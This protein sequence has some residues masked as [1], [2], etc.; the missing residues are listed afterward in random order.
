MSNIKTPHAAVVIWNYVNRLGAEDTDKS[1]LHDV[2]KVILST[3]SCISIKTAKSKGQPQGTFELRLAP[4]K[5]W[6]SVLSPGSWLA[7]LMSQQK[8]EYSDLVET[9]DPNKIKMLGRI[10]SV[11]A[12]VTVNQETGARSTE[13]I[14]QGSDWGGVFNTAIY[15]DPLI[16]DVGSNTFWG[17]WK[18]IYE[19]HAL[20]AWSTG[21]PSP[22][23][24][25]EVLLKLWGTDSNVVTNVNDAL[26]SLEGIGSTATFEGISP[27]TLKSTTVLRFPTEVSRY[28][29]FRQNSIADII[30]LNYEGIVLSN[31]QRYVDPD[32]GSTIYYDQ[33]KKIENEAVGIIQ[34]N[35]IFGTHTIWQLLI[36]NC[37]D[38][39]NELIADIRW[40]PKGKAELAL[41]RRVRPFVF[42]EDFI[43]KNDVID[44]T[45]RFSDVRTV[46]IPTDE[47][48]AVDIG[49]N[50][51]DKSNFTE[52]MPDQSLGDFIRPHAVKLQSQSFDEHAFSREGFRPIIKSTKYLAPTSE[53]GFDPYGTAKWKN[54]LREW[55][56]NTH[57]LLNGNIVF[58]GQNNYIQVGDNI[59]F[60]E[61]LITSSHNTNVDT[62]LSSDKNPKILAHVESVAHQFTVSINGARNFITTVSFVRGIAV[63]DDRQPLNVS[64]IIE[65]AEGRVDKNA[66]TMPPASDKNNR[67]ILGTSSDSD[68]DIE[69]LDGN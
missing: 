32:N 21:L 66:S 44:I 23:K 59:L 40:N 51:R 38:T 49:T 30:N 69:T 46:S 68:P 55:Y 25:M 64:S 19:Q 6:V 58:I 4:T 8:I 62:L 53:L 61:S 67:D 45:A 42:R 48:L 18:V 50:W 31:N 29:G 9:A 10:E 41:Y 43:G 12:H 1:T 24:N 3:V 60:D 34:P 47:V 20:E 37:N 39:L 65:P 26:N 52:V 63:G 35:T 54:L 33:Y 27:I 22:K 17:Q 56:F 28:F 2:E 11:R 13:Y 15:V 14:V 7:I 16:R 5:N 36:D 57:L